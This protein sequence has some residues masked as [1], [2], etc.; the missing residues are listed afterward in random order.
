[1][2]QLLA[3]QLLAAGKHVVDVP[4]KLA[5]RLRLLDSGQIN[6]TDEHDA[7]AVAVAALRT[8]ALPQL[9]VDDQTMVLRVWSRRYHD[10]A[11]LRTQAVC[12]LHALLCEL[13]PGGVRKRLPTSQ[14]SAIIES[15]SADSPIV[16]AKL[17]SS[18]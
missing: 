16:Q 5:A 2:E 7:Y 3:Q 10:L 12:R 15:V 11:R 9:A 8:G 1:L 14:A 17:D 6:K 18:P 4:A 13:V